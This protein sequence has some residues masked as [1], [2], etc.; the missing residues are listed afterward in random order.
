MPR[1]SKFIYVKPKRDL[2]KG[3][4][5]EDNSWQ[6]VGLANGNNIPLVVANAESYHAY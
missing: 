6:R 1:V 3:A 2:T 5:A 4:D